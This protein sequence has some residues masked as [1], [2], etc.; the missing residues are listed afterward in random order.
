MPT[1]NCCGIP[2]YKVGHDPNE[3][4]C[5]SGTCCL[6]FWTC[7]ICWEC[8]E[9]KVQCCC[10]SCRNKGHRTTADPYKNHHG[11]GVA[12]TAPPQQAMGYP[13]AAPAPY[14]THAA[15]PAGYASYP[16]AEKPVKTTTY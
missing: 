2:C 13:Q 4:A 6:R 9:E 1:F 7:A 15:T 11:H 8:S 5:C 10:F 3:H 14:N 16:A 12:T